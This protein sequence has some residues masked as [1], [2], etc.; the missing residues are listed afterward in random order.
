M[1]KDIYS[2]FSLLI[3]IIATVAG[4][5]LVFRAFKNRKKPEIFVILLLMGITKWFVAGVYVAIFIGI[6]PAAVSSV[7]TAGLLIRLALPLLLGLPA[8]LVLEAGI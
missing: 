6:V 2:Y 5:Y 1:L 3:I 8:I 7:F 4:T